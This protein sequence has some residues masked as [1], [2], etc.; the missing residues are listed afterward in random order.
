M[1]E[2]F[3]QMSLTEASFEPYRIKNKH[4]GEYMAKP[5]EEPKE[6]HYEQMSLFSI[7]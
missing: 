6:K 2:E 7:P 5:K 1:M 4:D 3:E